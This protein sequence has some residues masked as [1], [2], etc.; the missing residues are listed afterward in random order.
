MRLSHLIVL[1][2][3]HY[4]IR[5]AFLESHLLREPVSSGN[6]ELLWQLYVKNEQYLRAAEVLAALAQSSQCVIM[7]P[8]SVYC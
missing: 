4:Q 2:H 3:S 5:P 6:Y 8:C 7:I 1:F